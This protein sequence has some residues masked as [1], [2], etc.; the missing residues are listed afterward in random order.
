[1]T[2]DIS[3]PKGKAAPPSRDSYNINGTVSKGGVAILGP[4]NTVTIQQ[5]FSGL[6]PEERARQEA[7]LRQ[8]V[9][10]KIATLHS[11]AASPRP[12]LGNPYYSTEPLGIGDKNRL[13]GRESFLAEL[14]KRLQA[15]EVTFLCGNGGVGKT[16]LIQAGVIPALLEAGHLPMLV[17]AG[18]LPLDRGIKEQF[19]DTDLAQK[20]GLRSF[21][22][23]ISGE[24]EE[25]Q[26]I[27][28]LIDRLEEF[29]EQ[30]EEEQQAFKVLFEVI[31]TN[32][33]DV[34]WLFSI[35]TGASYRL[36]LFEPEVDTS[37]NQITLAPLHRTAA[38]EAIQAPANASL[39]RI[40]DSLLEEL[41]NKL[42]REWIDPAQ[43]QLVCFELAGGTGSPVTNWTYPYYESLGKVEGILQNYLVE[44]IDRFLPKNREPAWEILACLSDRNDKCLSNDQLFARMDSVYRVKK[45]QVVEILDLLKAKHLVDLETRYR[46]SSASLEERVQKWLAQRSIR[47][48][49]RDEVQQ[50]VRGI[51]ASALRG[52]LGG[53]IGFGLA[54][55]C[56]PYV[57]RP[58]AWDVSIFYYAYNVALRALFGGL[59]GFAMVLAIDLIAASFTTSAA[60][61]LQL[62]MAAGGVSVAFLLA[63]HTFLGYFGA[64]W[65]AALLKSAGEG[66]IWGALTGAGIM[67]CLERPAHKWLI[68]G[69]ASLVCGISLMLADLVLGGLAVSSPL[70]VALAGGVMSFFL[71]GSAN[72]GN[73]SFVRGG[74]L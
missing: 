66:A 22:E 28:I 20:M 48:K 38:A 52:L 17:T 73:H 21:L 11:Q 57:A 24:L 13:C 33:P 68:T 27:F 1:M 32:L 65:G 40:E 71:I 31:R 42:G 72:L 51:G 58:T 61:R 44:V 12:D 64:D 60:R 43:L 5:Y 34:H 55:I 29:F 25:N 69:V 35:H 47:E 8:S 3:E 63:T 56:L 14:I 41:L 4:D 74:G 26:A 19:A 36:G 10:R 30:G 46:L 49:A 15:R 16:S 37:G 6:A 70:A 59:A 2:P 67:L 45:E 50:Q 54:Y 62:S 23:F 9:S 18:S 7:Q 53:A 39:I